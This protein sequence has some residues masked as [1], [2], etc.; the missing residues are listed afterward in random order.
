MADLEDFEL[1][2]DGDADE[3]SVE[4]RA[5]AM[6]WKP[7][8]E[9][10][11]DSRRFLTAEEFI[12]KGEN[13]L[14]VLR[15]NV[16]RTTEKLV[17]QDG[18]IAALRATIE[19]QGQAVRD[20]MQ[21]ARSANDAGYKRAMDELK[22]KQREAAASGDIEAF[23]QIDQQITAAQV[24]REAHDKGFVTVPIPK[25]PDPA[26]QPGK[27][28][29][30]TTQ[31]IAANPWFNTKPVLK[32]AMIN[33]HAAIMA[34]E[35]PAKGAA[36]TDQYERAKAEVVEAFPHFFPSEAP[37]ADDDKPT[38]TPRPRPRLR[39]ALTPS[40]ENPPRHGSPF[41][42]IENPAE[43]AEARAAYANIL[44]WDKDCTEDEYV[45]L[46]LN[47]K[48]NPIELREQRRKAN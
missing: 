12:A 47:P 31:F 14:P 41:D 23:D 36:L 40:S 28:D 15:D 13:E 38:P 3:V 37:V 18:E 2:E 19:Q 35:G 26:P 22:A 25:E 33:A 16:R 17:K 4:A 34:A 46:Y 43:R 24:E 10:R 6:G 1:P 29:P 39:P 45:T 27:V 21:M 11:G 7:Q 42:R 5:R 20:A 8:G 30:E 48:T 44:K 9:H 32:G